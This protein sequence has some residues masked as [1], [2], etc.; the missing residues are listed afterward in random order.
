MS[1]I[2]LETLDTDKIIFGDKI[3]TDDNI[4]RYYLYYNDKNASNEI[5][6]KLPKIRM[7]F[8]N[9][10][11]QKYSQINIPIY[12]LWEQTEKYISLIKL[13]E[14]TVKEYFNTK[15]I[16]NSLLSEKNGLMLLK[17]K[18]KDLPKLTS[19]LNL[20]E[21]TFKDFKLNGEIEMVIKIS[22]IWLSKKTKKYGL[23]CQLCQVK[24]CGLPEQLYIDFIDEKPKIPLPPPINT[25]PDT[26]YKRSVIQSGQNINIVERKMPTKE[27]LIKAMLNLK[28]KM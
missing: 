4:S 17:M 15:Y 19:N 7:I 20:N 2:L 8:N 16:F 27:E 28:K 11:N 18:M 1:Y 24:Y 25:T 9:F 23:S 21:V 22:Y 5:Y 26:I 12:P 6:I 14:S 3:C 13:L 10:V